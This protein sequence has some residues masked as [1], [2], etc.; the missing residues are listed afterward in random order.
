MTT[1]WDARA[2]CPEMESIHAD[3]RQRRI[4]R[5][6]PLSMHIIS[7]SANPG[8]VLGTERAFR[9]C[10]QSF[11]HLLFCP[12][13][14][15]TDIHCRMRENK[16]VALGRGQRLFTGRHTFGPEQSAPS[17]GC[18]SRN[19][20]PVLGESLEN[21]SFCSPVRRVV[22]YHVYIKGGVRFPGRLAMELPV[23]PGHAQK[24]DFPLLPELVCCIEDPLARH[25]V[26]PAQEEDIRVFDRSRVK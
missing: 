23:M 15:K 1:F 26:E 9:K 18:V 24:A 5:I 8:H 4:R 12:R 3:I 19:P 17:G 16:A 22:T 13:P 2:D 6:K 11:L 7:D 20:G 25:P 14:G 21:L 10:G